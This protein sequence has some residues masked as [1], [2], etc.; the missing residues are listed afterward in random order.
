MRLTQ[1][2]KTPLEAR[3]YRPSSTGSAEPGGDG[4]LLTLSEVMPDVGLNCGACTVNVEPLG[5]ADAVAADCDPPPTISAYIGRILASPK[6]PATSAPNSASESSAKERWRRRPLSVSPGAAARMERWWEGCAVKCTA[7][8]DVGRSALA[9]RDKEYIKFPATSSESLAKDRWRWHCGVDSESGVR[10]EVDVVDGS[11]GSEEDGSASRDAFF[12][13]EE[14]VVVATIH[15]K[16]NREA[17]FLGEDNCLRVAPNFMPAERACIPQRL[18]CKE[19][20]KAF[21]H[22][23]DDALHMY[24]HPADMPTKL[25]YVQGLFTS[26]I[27]LIMLSTDLVIFANFDRF[28]FPNYFSGFYVHSPARTRTQPLFYIYTPFP[29][30]DGDD[31]AG[32]DPEEGRKDGKGGRTAPMSSDT[33]EGPHQD[34]GEIMIQTVFFA[35]S[36]AV[37]A[38]SAG[39]KWSCSGWLDDLGGSTRSCPGN[40]STG[41]E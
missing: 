19:G 31:A 29:G 8:A 14:L 5:S 7:V 26:P 32:K 40:V 33:T 34:V 28:S 1:P 16:A 27:A 15:L 21:Y 37:D 13:R 35:T 36:N 39:C 20:L 6:F 25:C 30:G 10:D 17:H 23:A 9:S 38:T 3:T 24:K 18:V 11:Y 12:G 4:A 22:D 2:E 41:M